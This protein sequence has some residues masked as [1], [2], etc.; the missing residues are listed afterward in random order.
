M[1]AKADQVTGTTIRVASAGHAVFAVTM[2]ALGILGL[3]NQAWMTCREVSAG[4]GRCSVWRSRLPARDY[5]GQI[6]DS[7]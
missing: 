6:V 5:F 1:P 3:D 7:T 2:I 4:T